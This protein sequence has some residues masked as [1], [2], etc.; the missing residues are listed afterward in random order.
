MVAK[1][2]LIVESPA[3]AIKIQKMFS[4]KGIIA[5]ASQGHIKD[6]AKGKE[7]INTADFSLQYEMMDDKKHVMD[8]IFRLINSNRGVKILIATDMDR[9]GEAIGYN[10]LEELVEHNS[11]K[12]TLAG[13]LRQK[14][15][16]VFN[17]ITEEALTEAISKPRTID[18]NMFHAQQARRVLDRLIGFEL[19]GVLWKHIRMGLSAGRCQS[20]AL[21][22]LMDR[23][24][25]IDSHSSEALFK[26]S[27]S[28][29]T[30][31]EMNTTDKGIKKK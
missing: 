31:L 20:P 24:K 21:Q 18:Q 22:L 1:T 23:E 17:E 3:K 13:A 26:M 10:L 16:I 8:S 27:G 7:G 29:E 12:G 4:G 15:R 19:S 2:L 25:D 11:I 6:L 9:E 14:N 30:T 5:I 28:V